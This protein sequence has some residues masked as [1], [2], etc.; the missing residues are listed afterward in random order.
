M[1]MSVVLGSQGW[2]IQDAAVTSSHAPRRSGNT[3]SKRSKVCSTPSSALNRP[4]DTWPTQVSMGCKALIISSS[5]CFSSYTALAAPC[6]F[7]QGPAFT[8]RNRLY[9]N[10]SR[11]HG[12]TEALRSS[13]RTY[14]QRERVHSRYTFN[15]VA[16][17]AR[18]GIVFIEEFHRISHV[19]Y[20]AFPVATRMLITR[21]TRLSRSFVKESQ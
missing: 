6:H 7:W 17:E 21:G 9:L 11:V 1:P 8:R 18:L 5:R 4:V 3:F 2:P 20:R 14:S 15:G 12:A 13:A 16:P 10:P 19:F